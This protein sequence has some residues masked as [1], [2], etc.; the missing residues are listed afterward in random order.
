MQAVM[1]T[2]HGKDDGFL[3]NRQ[4]CLC[5]SGEINFEQR[6]WEIR[7]EILVALIQEAYAWW[8]T[9]WTAV[10][11]GLL[12]SAQLDMPM[13]ERQTIR[14]QNAALKHRRRNPSWRCL[15]R[16]L[17]RE[18][19]SETCKETHPIFSL[20]YSFFLLHFVEIIKFSMSV[21]VGEF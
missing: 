18:Q 5:S 21:V 1:P 16:D 10:S 14:V 8:L 7:K 11:A 9:P 20:S 2:L 4:A 15:R 17:H 13:P 6:N 3:S 19:K 12:F